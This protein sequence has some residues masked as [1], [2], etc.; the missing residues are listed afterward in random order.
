MAA[1][2]CC[3]TTSWSAS[4]RSGW[5]ATTP[6]DRGYILDGFPRTVAQAEALAEITRRRPLDLV[7]DLEVPEEVVLERLSKRRVCVDC[8]TNYS[9]DPRP[10]RLGVRQLRRRGG[11]AR[12]RHRGGH[13]P[14]P[15]PLREQTEPLIAWYRSAT[16][17]PPSTASAPRRGDPP[18]RQAIDGRRAAAAEPVAQLPYA[19]VAP[20]ETLA[21]MRLPAG[22]WPRCTSASARPSGPGS[23]PPSSTGSAARCI[24]RRGAR[25][26][27]SARPRLPGGDLR[28][29]Q[30]RGR[31]RHPR[32]RV[33]DD[34][35][36]VSI[37][38][39]AIVDGWHGDAAFTAGGGRGRPPRRTAHRGGR[40][41]AR[42]RHRRH[43]RRRPAR[44]T[45]ARPSSG[46]PRR[47]GS[48]SCGSTSA[49]GSA[50]R[51]TSRP[52]VPNT[53]RRARA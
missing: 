5:P 6:H 44:P 2:S 9:V 28:L 25:R 27:S 12:R 33:L 32:R 14:P 46:S 53:A 34:G 47:P 45:S 37:D 39:G 20:A 35:D 17:W 51:C 21:K 31:P 49:T 40:G 41:V 24:D 26:T 29:A 36:I 15:R 23:P 7:V 19:G 13:P 52:D 42:R 18:P 4:S 1:A 11:P 8:G 3:P 48:R 10:V 16:C 22:S 38:C 30:R 50:G 43:G